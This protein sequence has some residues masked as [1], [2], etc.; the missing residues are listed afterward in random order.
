MEWAG[1]MASEM[2]AKGKP[3]L[4]LGEEQAKSQSRRQRTPT[5]PDT[6]EEEFP[7]F[8]PFGM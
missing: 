2:M 4:D 1:D 5:K 3:F 7:K 8:T 6:V